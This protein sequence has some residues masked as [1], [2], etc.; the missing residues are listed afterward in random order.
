MGLTIIFKTLHLSLI[1]VDIIDM[2]IILLICF[3]FLQ[4]NYIFTKYSVCNCT[5]ISVL[6]GILMSQPFIV[7]P[8]KFAD[9]RGRAETCKG[10]KP[11]VQF[12]SLKRVY[13]GPRVS[14][15]LS[16]S[17]PTGW[18]SSAQIS[19]SSLRPFNAPTHI[20]DPGAVAFRTIGIHK[21]GYYRA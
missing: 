15:L 11:F 12:D 6:H 8:V 7:S 9:H 20:G 21:S 16:I 5:Y 2:F 14:F 1:R 17:E 19:L 4:L 13:F 10:G 3:F 18:T